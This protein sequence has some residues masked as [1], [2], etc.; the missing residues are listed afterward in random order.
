MAKKSFLITINKE[1][2]KELERRAKRDRLTVQELV[3]KI[4][5]RSAISSLRKSLSPKRAEKYLEIFSRYR[6][7]HEEERKTYY[8]NKCE[9]RHRYESKIGKKH[10]KYRGKK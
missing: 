10:I 6:P 3:N 9:K 5:W 8:C 4:L 2:F 7:Y 1:L